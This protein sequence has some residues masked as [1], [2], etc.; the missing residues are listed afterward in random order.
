MF[1]NVHKYHTYDLQQHQKTTIQTIFS[2]T[3][4]PS[5]CP[6]SYMI[7]DLNT[8]VSYSQFLEQ[9]KWVFSRL[10]SYLPLWVW[11]TGHVDGEWVLENIW[12]IVVVVVVL[13]LGRHI[14]T[15]LQ[16]GVKPVFDL[17]LLRCL[18]AIEN[19]NKLY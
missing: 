15:V 17:L 3:H 16:G 18:F 19:R 14:W 9:V 8:Y 4:S 6:V 5:T 10:Q 1:I 11:R 12:H 2:R 13:I 7:C